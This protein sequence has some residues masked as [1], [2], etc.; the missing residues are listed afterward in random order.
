MKNSCPEMYSTKSKRVRKS[1]AGAG[2]KL[3][4]PAKA[5]IVVSLPTQG[6]FAWATATLTGA[7]TRSLA[8]WSF[9]FLQRFRP[10]SAEWISET[11]I[12]PSPCCSQDLRSRMM[13]D[14][15]RLR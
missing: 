9:W 13:P 10:C 4:S 7:K 5:Q 3:S 11:S 8:L 15:A 2:H 6:Y 1:R 12:C 14:T